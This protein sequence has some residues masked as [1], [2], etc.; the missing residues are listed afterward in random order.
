[1]SFRQLL[2]PVGANLSLSSNFELHIAYCDLS[3]A[4]NSGR[5]RAY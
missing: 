2:R 4:D 3:L 1:M 5:V